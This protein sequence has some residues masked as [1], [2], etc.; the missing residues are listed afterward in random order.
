MSMRRERA[1]REEIDMDGR[2]GGRDELG[3]V[4]AT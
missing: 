1:G 4:G 3:L 2:E